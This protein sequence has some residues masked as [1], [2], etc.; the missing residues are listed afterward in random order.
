MAQGDTLCSLRYLQPPM[1]LLKT[2]SQRGLGLYLLLAVVKNLWWTFSSDL[3]MPCHECCGSE[4]QGEEWNWSNER[5]TPTQCC[6]PRCWGCLSQWEKGECRPPAQ[7]RNT[8]RRCPTLSA[9]TSSF[10]SGFVSGFGSTWRFQR[11][12]CTMFPSST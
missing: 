8:E 3:Y 5:E 11:S 1:F 4:P 6:S 7:G 10:S 12:S 9:A 2:Q